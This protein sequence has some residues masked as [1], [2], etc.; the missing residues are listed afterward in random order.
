[1]KKA[2]AWRVGA[3]GEASLIRGPL[4]FIDGPLPTSATS[5]IPT[6]SGSSKKAHSNKKTPY[7]K[8][9]RS[10]PAVSNSEPTSFQLVQRNC[11]TNPA[12]PHCGVIV[13]SDWKFCKNCGVKIPRKTSPIMKK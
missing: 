8:A 3:H 9:T 7:A 4:L 13:N 5:S 6:R 12:H 1:M 11:P 10:E 2:S